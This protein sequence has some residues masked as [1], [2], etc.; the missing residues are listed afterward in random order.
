[1]RAWGQQLEVL[2]QAEDPRENSFPA[3]DVVWSRSVL[4]CVLG[5]YVS[6]G[7][8]SDGLP[9]AADETPQS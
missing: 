3:L 4:L 5:S 8:E 2:P 6:R 1:M 9:A 7:V